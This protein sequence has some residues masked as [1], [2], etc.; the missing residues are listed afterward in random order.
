MTQGDGHADDRG[1][2]PTVAALRRAGCVFAEDEA[3]IL[4]E[5]AASAVHLEELLAARTAGVPLEHVVGHVEFGGL[6]LQV[7]PGVFVPR[8]RTLLLAELTVHA[9]RAARSSDTPTP[10]FVE[11]FSGVA[12]LAASVHAAAPRTEIHVT[13]IDEQALA[14]ACANAG[15]DSGVHRGDV[16]AGLPRRLRGTVAVIAAVPPYVPVP[17]ASLL[18]REARDHEPSAALFGGDDGLAHARALIEQS[19]AWLRAGG[20]VLVELH[21]GQLDEALRTVDLR[22][23]SVAPHRSD[24]GQTVVLDLTASARTCPI[25]TRATDRSCD[26][27]PS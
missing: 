15:A 10:V 25:R 19:A 24:D 5:A 21:A 16:L 3:R 20:R 7:G 12:P 9:V 17:H 22:S 18:P 2:D 8:Q 11:A 23:F 14:F 6:R 26:G 1:E 13:D 4:R 27:M